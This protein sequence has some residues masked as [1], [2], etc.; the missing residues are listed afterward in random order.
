MALELEAMRPL[1]QQEIDEV[2]GG[3]ILSGSALF[4]LV[5]DAARDFGTGFADGVRSEMG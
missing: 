3:L 5:Y 1:S 4:L 2:S